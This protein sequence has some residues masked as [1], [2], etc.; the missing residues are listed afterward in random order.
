[1]GEVGLSGELRSVS[2][3]DRRLGEASKLGF[4][5]AVSPAGPQ[6]LRIEGQTVI[7]VRSLMDAVD[8]ALGPRPARADKGKASYREQDEDN[9]EE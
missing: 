5:H 3:M 9:E 7:E 1:M 6:P 8:A 4:T 2:Q